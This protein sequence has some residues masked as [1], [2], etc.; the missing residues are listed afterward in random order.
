MTAHPVVRVRA[1]HLST[2][3]SRARRF[4]RDLMPR[5]QD[6]GPDPFAE[7]G[8]A[9]AASPADAAEEDELSLD[10]NS[11]KKKKKKKVGGLSG[12]GQGSWDHCTCRGLVFVEV[13]SVAG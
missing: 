8:A 4:S 3:G 2:H 10:L 13:W 6:E 11:K 5:M 12:E 7:E 9:P 1:P